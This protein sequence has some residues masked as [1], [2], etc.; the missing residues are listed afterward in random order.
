MANNGLLQCNR[1]LLVLS[2][3]GLDCLEPPV[4]ARHRQRWPYPKEDP[5]APCVGGQAC[6]EHARQCASTSWFTA[7]RYPGLQPEFLPIRPRQRLWFLSRLLEQDDPC[8]VR[9]PTYEMSSVGAVLMV[10]PPEEKDVLLACGMAAD[11]TAVT[12]A[13]AARRALLRTFEAVAQRLPPHRRFVISVTPHAGDDWEKFA[14]RA[15]VTGS[16]LTGPLLK[17]KSIRSPR[18]LLGIH[19][20]IRTIGATFI[21]RGGV[22]L[23]ASIRLLPNAMMGNVMGWGISVDSPFIPPTRSCL[24]SWQQVLLERA[25]AASS[26]RFLMASNAV[27]HGVSTCL[28]R[29]IAAACSA[30]HGPCTTAPP[31]ECGTNSHGAVV[32]CNHGSLGYMALWRS[33]TYCL[34]PA[35]D[36]L[37]RD[38]AL[39]QMIDVGCIPVFFDGSGRGDLTRSSF[40]RTL[41]GEEDPDRWSVLVPEAGVLGCTTNELLKDSENETVASLAAG[42]NTGRGSACHSM[43]A[44]ARATGARISQILAAIPPSRVYAMRA[45]AANTLPRRTQA[46]MRLKGQPDFVDRLVSAMLSS[47]GSGVASEGNVAGSPNSWPVGI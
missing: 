3:A 8:V 6:E 10:Q 25:R 40:S 17:P 41:F 34:M 24:A 2:S 20:T 35:G 21:N 11:P 37:D 1:K 22:L 14:L 44:S 18:A 28:R 31:K 38:S 30:R 15:I 42:L 26:T 4:L 32:W 45:F 46:R 29:K 47:N 33:A 9:T 43:C 19:H 7:R 12:R 13:L 36:G 5:L 39:V 23:G 27:A 16:L